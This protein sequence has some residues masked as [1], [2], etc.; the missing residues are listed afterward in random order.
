MQ[1]AMR[2]YGWLL[3]LYPA[4]FREEYEPALER[5]FQDDYRDAAS[6]G[7]AARLWSGAL[8]DLATSVPRQIL[9]EMRVDIRQGMRAYQR[10]LFSTA[11]AVIALALAIGASTGIFSVMNALLLRSLPFGRPDRLVELWLSPMNAFAGRAGFLGWWQ[12]SAY[13]NEAATFSTSEMNLAA[14]QEAW[15]VKGTESSANFFH[16]LGVNAAAGRTFAHDEDVFGQNSVAVIGYGLWQQLFGGDPAAIGKK[17]IHV[18]GMEFTVIGVMP[19]NFNY[20]GNTQVWM[21]TI[22]DFEKIPHRGAFLIETIGRLKNEASLRQARAMFKVEVLRRNAK[23]YEGSDVRNWPKLVS[24]QN[25]LAGPVREQSW[26]LAGMALLV[27][28]T[29][30]ANVAQL[31]LSRATERSQELAVRAALGASR[32]RLLQQLITEAV[33]FTTVSTV[34]GLG[35]AQWICGLATA[36]V[37][38]ELATQE[39]TIFDWRVLGFAAGLAVLTAVVFGLSSAHLTE[40]L[41]PA[42]NSLRSQRSAPDAGM[43]R[44]RAMLIVMQAAITLCLVTSSFA[45]GNAFLK[46]LGTDLGYRTGNVVTLNVSLQGTTHRGKGEW[47]YY[48]DVLSRLRAMPEVEAAS[49][50]SYLPLANQ[51]YMANSFK[52]DSGQSVATVVTNAVMPGYFRVMGTDFLNGRDFEQASGEQG[53]REVIVN[54]TFARLSGLGNAIVGRHVVSPWTGAPYLV[55]G[56]VRMARLNGPDDGGGPQI[57]FYIREETPPVLTFVAK[58]RGD[59]AV[60]LAKCRD[61]VRGIDPQ[62]PIYDVKTLDERLDEVLARPRFYVG[63]TGLLSLMTALLAMV[64]IYGTTSYALEQRRREMGIRMAVGATARGLRGMMIWESARPLVVGV[65]GGVGL[66]IFTGRFLEDLLTSVV[67]PDFA[68][69]LAGGVALVCVG[70]LAAWQATALVRRIDPMEALRAE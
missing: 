46:L 41:Q 7:E 13:L 55:E 17:T 67:R 59:A 19:A 27:L 39:Y 35:L 37:P 60:G 54:D 47:A 31:I 25:Q 11:L 57:Y 5:Q 69:C 3:K 23:A 64:G 38:P 20:P 28:L 26:V 29:A 2:V 34:L 61:A 8:W 51:I 56:V 32:A 9:S 24:L 22:F 66:A 1:R 10:R 18:N 49:A 12:H 16:L 52:L 14:S 33:L 15:R 53:D 65:A 58:V 50:V 43:K 30:C 21:P 63:V 45:L 44:A 62:V 42:A 68:T 40:R 36:I 4:R 48:S 70:V 6:R